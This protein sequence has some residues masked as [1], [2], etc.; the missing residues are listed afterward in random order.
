MMAS[1]ED[2]RFTR[3]RF[4]FGDAFEHFSNIKVAI[5]GVGG[6]GGFALD[7]LYRVG[8]GHQS[9]GDSKSVGITIVD[10]DIF[11]ITNQNRQIGSEAVG[12]IK[13]EVLAKIYPGILPIQAKVNQDFINQFDFD[14][15]DYVIDAIDDIDAKVMLAKACENK[16]YGRYICSTGS[17]K[18]LNPLEIRVDSIWRSYGDRFGKKLREALKKDNFKG[19]FK[20]IFSPETPKCKVLGS[21]SAVTASFGL[22][23]G[24]E[25]VRDILNQNKG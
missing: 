7:S 13:V 1:K 2:D 16:P 8:I 22:Q 9:N 21:F 19:D 3:T 24:S 18:K 15:Y 25:V 23:I 12:E 6:V 5:F 17:A 14:S 10:K 4:L 20:V 11:D